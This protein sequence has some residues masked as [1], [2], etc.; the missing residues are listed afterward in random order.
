MVVF[1][2]WLVVFCLFVVGFCC[3]FVVAFFLFRGVGGGFIVLFVFRCC[4]FWCSLFC[5]LLLG[6]GEGIIAVSSVKKRGEGLLAG[7]NISQISART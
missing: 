2:V 3:F 1:F 6:V 7:Q 5:L 4:C